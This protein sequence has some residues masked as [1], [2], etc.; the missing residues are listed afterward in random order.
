MQFSVPGVSP[1]LMLGRSYSSPNAVA[2][3]SP[4]SPLSSPSS[5]SSTASSSYFAHPS[6]SAGTS[7]ATHHHSPLSLA[8]L[9]AGRSRHASH[10]S[11]DGTSDGHSS[12]HP[13]TSSQQRPSPASL[14]KRRVQW[15]TDR[16]IG[17][18]F[19]AT[20]AAIAG[21]NHSSSPQFPIPTSSSFPNGFSSSPQ[22]S[23]TPPA[24]HSTPPSPPPSNPPPPQFSAVE[25]L[26][27]SFF[28]RDHQMVNFR[29]RSAHRSS[30]TDSPN[31]VPLSTTAALHAAARVLRS[32]DSQ[33]SETSHA[34]HRHSRDGGDSVETGGDEMSV[35]DTTEVDPGAISEMSKDSAW[36][37][38]TY[39]LTTRRHPINTKAANPNPTSP[40]NSK[41]P[42]LPFL[43]TTHAASAPVPT[44]D[45]GLPLLGVP[46][47]FLWT[48]VK[49]CGGP[50][51]L[52]GMTTADVV[53]KF[54][55]PRTANPF[56]WT[57]PSKSL[58]EHLRANHHEWVKEASWFISHAWGDSFLGLVEA[59]TRCLNEQNGTGDSEML[60]IDIFSLP[61]Q[62]THP[63]HHQH[64]QQ[65]HPPQSPTQL[66]FT[67]TSKGH[68]A[69]SAGH[70]N[71][72]KDPHIPQLRS[73]LGS[74]SHFV[75]VCQKWSSPLAFQRS[76]C[77]YE[78][79]CL[80][81]V[82]KR[83]AAAESAV[84]ESSTSDDSPGAITHARNP[85]FDVAFTRD[86][87][88]HLLTSL[89]NDPGEFYT[90][91]AKSVN[92]RKSSATS[93][94]ETDALH[95]VMRQGTSGDPY[96]FADTTIFGLLLRWLLKFIES[97]IAQARDGSFEKSEWLDTLGVL[98]FHQDLLAEAESHWR[99]S[100]AIKE[101]IFGADDV[102]NTAPIAYNLALLFEKRGDYKM[103]ESWYNDSIK[104]LSEQLGPSHTMT[105][106]ILQSLGFLL[107]GEGK[108]EDAERVLRTVYER[109]IS[110]YGPASRE[111][112]LAATDLATHYTA[113]GDLAK[114]RALFDRGLLDLNRRTLGPHHIASLVAQCSYAK[115][116][117]FQDSP[118]IAPNTSLPPTPPPTDNDKDTPCSPLVGPASKSNRQLAEELLDEGLSTLHR[119]KTSFDYVFLPTASPDPQASNPTPF[120][121]DRGLHD[122]AIY[123]MRNLL[124]SAQAILGPTHHITLMVQNSIGVSLAYTDLEK[125]RTA[126]E[127]CVEKRLRVYGPRHKETV[128]AEH[129][130]HSVYLRF[131]FDGP[132][133]KEKVYPRLREC[134]E[135]TV[136]VLGASH[137]CADTT[138]FVLAVALVKGQVA[139]LHDSAPAA[140]AL[141]EAAELFRACWTARA[142]AYGPESRNAVEAAVWLADVL[143]RLGRTDKARDVL[144]GPSAA[145]ADH[146]M[147][148]AAGAGGVDPTAA[149]LGGVELV[150]EVCGKD[151]RLVRKAVRVMEALAKGKKR[152]LD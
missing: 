130:L 22:A 100:L 32:G 86:D 9:T 60:W 18:C 68:S 37:E 76:W 114:A 17:A 138:A 29:W 6:S 142:A 106:H 121:R 38:T 113:T 145:A 69:A 77:L 49:E 58:C 42:L 96:A 140:A 129:N 12:I 95:A 134:R 7:S 2:S 28:R 36:F 43:P 109:S 57:G 91:L 59:V 125:A 111:T 41:R 133:A 136:A 63:L 74:F 56:Q 52:K 124:G 87:K 64:H 35:S 126:L 144:C 108:L 78:L 53:A 61:Q 55:R 104:L 122:N 102:R 54:I 67:G 135:T 48:F 110:V 72:S 127:D 31:D 3:S 116:L 15:N 51:V 10:S 33:S 99:E 66:R 65:Q 148:V 152:A 131:G 132:L 80:A 19:P 30:A 88:E 143:V 14:A 118:V 5:H 4:A 105:L 150:R 62:Q 137:P 85:S 8:S 75:F 25:R 23:V 107:N 89:Y 50:A 149:G 70:P 112:A 101:A 90:V 98:C 147:T 24:H 97:Q 103:A 21:A 11:T 128:L 115:V 146:S 40:A 119:I 120:G 84:D 47:W 26:M 82:A 46:L 93:S 27:L 73:A 71:D 94:L 123:M 16:A 20:R 141:V 45:D 13:S 117:A 83:A 81:R 39:Y 151:D 139:P 92:T 1:S 34:A 79:Y 44:S